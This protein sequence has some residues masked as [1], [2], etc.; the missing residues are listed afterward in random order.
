[1]NLLPREGV[2]HSNLLESYQSLPDKVGSEMSIFSCF[3]QSCLTKGGG[4]RKQKRPYEVHI[5]EVQAS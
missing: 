2:N 4:K 1:M 3:Y 5:P